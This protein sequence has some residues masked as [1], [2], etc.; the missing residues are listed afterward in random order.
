MKNMNMKEFKCFLEMSEDERLEQF[1]G[2]V[3]MKWWQKT[4][5]IYLNK[6]WSY[7]RNENPDLDVMVLWESIYKGRF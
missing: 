2:S 6:W 3:E 1:L 5:F 4:Y 7:M